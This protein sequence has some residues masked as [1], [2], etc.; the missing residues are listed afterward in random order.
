MEG[1]NGVCLSSV[2]VGDTEIATHQ[3]ATWDLI[4]RC[5]PVGV[6][7]SLLLCPLSLSLSVS[8]SVSTNMHLDNTPP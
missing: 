7:L 4:S 2:S 8:L 6:Y 3:T 1:E 5:C